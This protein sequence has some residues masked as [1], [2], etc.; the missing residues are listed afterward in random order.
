[1]ASIQPDAARRLTA[2]GGCPDVDRHPIGSGAYEW[3]RAPVSSRPPAAPPEIWPGT[4]FP[5]G[6]TFDGQGTNFALWSTTARQ[7]SVCL[8]D[9]D[10]TEIRVALPE[11]TFDI[12]HGYVPGV[13][14]GRR[15][16]L[17]TDGPFQPDAGFFHDP[18]NLLLDPYTRAVD[19]TFVDSPSVYAGN[20]DDSAPNVPRSVVV[21]PAGFDWAGDR[22]P[23]VPWADTV[24]YEAHVRGF[25]RCLTTVPAELRGTYAGL[26]HPGAVQYLRELGITAVELLPVH[27]SITEPSIQR[28]G[29]VNYWGYNSIGFFAPHSA[30]AA[31]SIGDGTG[32]IDEFKAM[33]ASLHRAGIEVLLDVVYNH[34]GE[35]AVTGPT[36]SLRGLDNHGYYWHAYDFSGEYADFTGCGNTVDT[37]TDAVLALIMDSLRYWVEEMHV[38]GFRFDLASALS[39]STHGFDLQSAFLSAIDQDPVLKTVK[40]IAEPWDV[41]AGGYQVGGFP[42]LWSEWNGKY[43]DTMRDFWAYGGNGVRDLAYRLAGSSDLY[44]DDGRLPWASVNFVTAHDGFT[45]R[46]LVSYGAKHNEANGEHNTDGSNDNRS[47]NCGVEGESDDPAITTLRLRQARNLL[48]S[49]LLSTGVPMITAGDERWRTQGGNNNAYCLDDET[50]WID[51]TDSEAADDLTHLTRRLLDLRRQSP[52]LRRRDFFDGSI[53][54]GTGGCRDVAWFGAGGT[55]LADGEW[56]DHSL[57]TLGMYLD[58]RGLRRRGA[59][60]EVITDDSYL[61]ILHAGDVGMDF[62][63]PGAPWATSYETVVDTAL[64]GGVPGPAEPPSPG[65]PLPLL[66]RCA[67]LLRVTH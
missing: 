6:A 44:A 40:L 39:R 22:R 57:R 60:G 54:D 52:V 38:D 65:K 32:V 59:H 56:F 9:D 15:Y 36:L 51:W 20:T 30:Y 43:R 29:M 2:R 12:W 37:R 17:R 48:T 10:G 26:G 13:R 8:F 34:T 61:L 25:T 27:A 46:D 55:E 11:R 24:I 16:G 5:L 19:G 47:F 62:V 31:S 67:V 53:I 4:P 50:S 45:L 23:K 14:P 66:P 33:V 3:S 21:G 49:L 41:A 42:T 1:M 64:P 35:G 63:L 28:R 18:S 58:G 7:A